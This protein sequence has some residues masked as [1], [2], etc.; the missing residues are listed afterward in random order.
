[1][2][3]GELYQKEIEDGIGSTGIKAGPSCAT[4]EGRE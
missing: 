2:E 4:G 1:V 3:V